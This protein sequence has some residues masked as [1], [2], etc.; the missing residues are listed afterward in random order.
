MLICVLLNPAYHINA[1]RFNKARN[2]FLKRGRDFF[3]RLQS[4][5]ANAIC[6]TQTVKILLLLEQSGFVGEKRNHALPP[7]EGGM[8][9]TARIPPTKI[10]CNRIG[11]AFRGKL[12]CAPLRF[13]QK[14][15][16]RWLPAT[17][18]YTDCKSPKASLSCLR[19]RIVAVR[20]AP[21]RNLQ[22][23]VAALRAEFCW[24]RK[25]PR[26]LA[27]RGETSPLLKKNKCAVNLPV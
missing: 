6:S 3:M 22:R 13:T 2:R 4:F 14:S 11:C 7:G 16:S 18:L 12:G 15:R 25:N 21:H 9:K 10:V 26:G 5:Y 20:R 19:K 27:A 23:I 24:Q 8:P 17:A 1:Q